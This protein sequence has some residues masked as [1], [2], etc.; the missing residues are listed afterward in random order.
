M[1]NHFRIA[2]PVSNLTRTETMYKIGLGLQRLGH[3]EDH[4]GFDGVMLG[5]Q[6][7]AYHFEFTYCR[8]HPVK[9]TPTPDDLLVF[10]VADP[11]DWGNCCESMQVAG[12]L[13]VPS[14]NPFWDVHGRTFEDPDG[15]RMIIQCATWRNLTDESRA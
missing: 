2:R 9:P 5:L 10:Y 12:F 4:D 8:S 15:Y 6:G 7:E 3:F 11:K 14:L 1:I 13:E